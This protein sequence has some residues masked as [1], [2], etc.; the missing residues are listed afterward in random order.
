MSLGIEKSALLENLPLVRIEFVYFLI[1]CFE[2]KATL[3]VRSQISP[4]LVQRGQFAPRESWAN[5]L[6]SHSNFRSDSALV[7]GRR[8]NCSEF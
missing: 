6:S 5:L 7:R 4:I 8:C 1:P 3:A 2:L